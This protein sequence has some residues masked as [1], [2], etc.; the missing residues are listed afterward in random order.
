MK[1]NEFDKWIATK[2]LSNEAIDLIGKIRKSDPAR[3]VGSG[4]ENV[5]GFYPSRKM[6]VTIQFESHTLELAAIYEK[7]INETVL[8]YYDQPNQFKINFHNEKGKKLGIR[9]TP[10]FFVIE[11]NWIGWE[12]WKEEEALKN[13]SFKY[14]DRYLK[15]E[16]DAWRC[17]PAERYAAQYGV[18]FRVRSSSEINWTY[19]RNIRFLE[20]YLLNPIKVKDV[21]RNFILNTIRLRPSIKLD[22]I[23]GNI[24]GV[25]EIDDVYQLIANGEIVVDLQSEDICDRKNFSLH[26]SIES[27]RTHQTIMKTQVENDNSISLRTLDTSI[28]NKIQWGVEIWEIKNVTGERIYIENNGEFTDLSLEYFESLILS[29]TVKG[30][31]NKVISNENDN[32]KELI[33]TMSERDSKEALHRYNVVM[34]IMNGAKYDEFNES[35]RTI[36]NWLKKYKDAEKKY[37]NGYVGLIPNKKARGNR[38]PKLEIEVIELMEEIIKNEYENKKQKNKN[39][40]YNQFIKVCKNK[41]YEPPAYKTFLGYIKKRPIHNQIKKRKGHKAAYATEEFFRLDHL[42]TPRHGSRPF[43]IVHIDHTE[44]DIEL[45]CSTT[46]KNLGRPWI[47]F[48]VDAYT[49]KVLAFYL[50]FDS[51]S[52]KSCMMVLRELVNRYKRKPSSII[53]DGGKEFESVYFEQLLAVLKVTKKKRPPTKARF[54]NVVERLFGTMNKQFIHNLMGNTQITKNVRQVIKSFNPKN[55]A[56]WTLEALYE[57]IK[58]YTYDIYDNTYHTTLAISPNELYVQSLSD[59]GK[60]TQTYV[61]DMEGFYFLTL[62][63]TSKGTAKVQIN[64][65]VKIRNTYYWTDRFRNPKFQLKEVKIKYDPFDVGIAY[66]YLDNQWVE[67][68]SEYYSVLKGRTEKEIKLITSEIRKQD[69]L[70]GVNKAMTS[71]RLIEFIDRAEKN[72]VIELQRLKD[73][74]LKKIIAPNKGINR[75]NTDLK[76]EVNNVIEMSNKF[77]KQGSKDNVKSLSELKRT[78]LLE[79][80]KEDLEGFEG[81]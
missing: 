8:E 15:D 80:V 30:L 31:T 29:G 42:R 33:M 67:M 59:T 26:L 6:G 56:T 19:Q 70:L 27:L 1:D 81:F 3:R 55:N 13:L 40:V 11:E 62:P 25:Y 22:E 41:G 51:P 47:T 63:S 4:G 45:V 7:E 32:Y 17:P 52:Y 66:A 54:G 68:Y 53:V 72:E 43:E 48:A 69:K 20:D 28:G 77:E 37:G 46:G 50:T 14:P 23:S 24:E 71:T 44:L 60:R 9:Y 12:E 34:G 18:S 64:E 38:L 2:G 16:N 57:L 78:K 73:E 39:T 65:G 76:T 74:A 36:R 35:E 79:Q 61:T 58:E 5:P 75:N 10:D 49:R 21:T